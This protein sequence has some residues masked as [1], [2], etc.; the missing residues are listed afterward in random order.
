MKIRILKTN[1]KVSESPYLTACKERD[2]ILGNIEMNHVTNIE[3]MFED[4]KPYRV[5]PGENLKRKNNYIVVGPGD[6]WYGIADELSKPGVF[7]KLA[8]WARRQK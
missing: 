1:R 3:D 4:S 2:G 6:D 8:S 7:A 5:S